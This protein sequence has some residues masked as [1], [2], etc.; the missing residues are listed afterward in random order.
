MVVTV[1]KTGRRQSVWDR[2]QCTSKGRFAR[3]I[4]ARTNT[5]NQTLDISPRQ[6][7]GHLGGTRIGRIRWQVQEPTARSRYQLSYFAPL[8]NARIVQ[9]KN[10][11]RRQLAQKFLGEETLKVNTIHGSQLALCTDHS[12]TIKGSNPRQVFASFYSDL[13]HKVFTF[14]AP[15]I[16]DRKCQR[17]SHFVQKDQLPWGDLSNLPQELVS[18]E[19]ITFG[20]NS[21]L[22]LNVNSILFRVRQTVDSQSGFPPCSCQAAVRLCSVQSV[23]E[24]AKSWKAWYC[25]LVTWGDLPGLRPGSSDHPWRTL[26]LGALFVRFFRRWEPRRQIGVRCPFAS[27]LCP[28]RLRCVAAGQERVPWGHAYQ[29]ITI[30]AKDYKMSGDGQRGCST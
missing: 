12:Q 1:T 7:N 24:R 11:A 15:A 10:R 26:V 13:L 20:C 22:F 2:R 30:L 5:T 25:S 6:L 23:L 8:V 16:Q 29:S 9:N 27:V 17:D 18:F 14:L 3:R 28:V 21:A 19:S 4:R